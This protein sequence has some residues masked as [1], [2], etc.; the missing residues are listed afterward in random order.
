MKVAR[1]EL[2]RRLQRQYHRSHPWRLSNGGL[3]IPHSYEDM[4]PDSLSWWDD[5]GF[6]LNGRR[7]IVWWQH[8]RH[9]Y[10]DAL[11]ERSWQE[12]G[13]GP[14]D[15]WLTDGGTKN[16]RRVGRSRKKLVSYT[17]RQ[18]SAE[19]RQHYDLLQGI[20]ERLT[21]EGIDLEVSINWKWKRMAW[22]MG[23][24]LVAPMEVRNERELASV[25][26]LARRLILGQTTLE[27]EFPGYRYGRADWLREQRKEA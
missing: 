9:V 24:S 16:Y 23:L 2:L 18:P 8:P 15:N 4:K 1:L 27:A 12:A 21:T 19:Q 7:V 26:I 3:F 11:H 17:I 6:I 20:L 10:A 13:D 22:A 5:V 14:R 25:A